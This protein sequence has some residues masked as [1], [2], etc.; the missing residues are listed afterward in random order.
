MT[1]P[2]LTA[3]ALVQTVLLSQINLWDARPDLMLLIV[4]VWSVVRSVDEGMV[5]GFIGGLIVDL[6]SGGPLGATALALLAVAFLVGQP[7]GQGRNSVPCPR[8]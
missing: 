1:I 4:L 6:L 3:V 2:L 7:W 5:W 8:L